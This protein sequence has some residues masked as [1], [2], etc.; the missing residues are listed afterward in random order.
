M[1]SNDESQEKVI[2]T[3]GFKMFIEAWRSEKEA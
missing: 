1:A 2:Y 3:L